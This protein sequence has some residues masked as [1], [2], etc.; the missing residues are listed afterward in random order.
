[1][2]REKKRLGRRERVVVG[3]F[4]KGTAAE[5]GLCTLDTKKHTSFP[6]FSSSEHF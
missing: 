1:M 3:R 5:L 6:D 4:A 2:G